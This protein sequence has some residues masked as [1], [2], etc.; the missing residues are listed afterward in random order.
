[1]RKIECGCGEYGIEVSD[2]KRIFSFGATCPEC[3]NAFG[4]DAQPVGTERI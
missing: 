1:M 2:H 3:G 4:W